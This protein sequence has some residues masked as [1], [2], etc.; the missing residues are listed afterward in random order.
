MIGTIDVDANDRL[1]FEYGE[2]DFLTRYR[3]T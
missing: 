2:G 3:L 1:V